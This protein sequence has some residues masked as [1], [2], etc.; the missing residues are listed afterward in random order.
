M[1]RETEMAAPVSFSVWFAINRPTL[2]AAS[3]FLA[4][5]ERLGVVL[6][7]LG[8]KRVENLMRYACCGDR[9]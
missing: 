5:D 2:H 6:Q 8:G 3:P 4:E 9:K 1:P 7:H